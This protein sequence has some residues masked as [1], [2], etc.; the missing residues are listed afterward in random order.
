MKFAAGKY[1]RAFQKKE[2]NILSCAKMLVNIVF[3]FAKGPE[4]GE[5]KRMFHRKIFLNT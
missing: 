4:E 5:K 2:M 1:L 3:L